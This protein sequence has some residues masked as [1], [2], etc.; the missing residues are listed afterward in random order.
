MR[1]QIKL[2]ATNGRKL[3]QLEYEIGEMT[4]DKYQELLAELA[5]KVNR[6]DFSG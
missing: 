4:E 2:Y 3:Q 5:V 1:I 6:P